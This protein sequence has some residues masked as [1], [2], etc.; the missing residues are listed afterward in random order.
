[1]MIHGSPLVSRPDTG[2]EENMMSLKV[3]AQ[4]GLFLDRNHMHRK[5]FRVANGRIVEAMGAVTTTCCFPNEPFRELTLRFYVL[6][7]LI[8]Q[9]VMG[10]PFLEETRVLVENRHRLQPRKRKS[11]HPQVSHVNNSKHRLRCAINEVSA[12]AVPDTGSDID[13]MSMEY[14]KRR[15]FV[16]EP[17]DRG[18]SHIQFIDGGTAVLAGKVT[19]YVIIDAEKEVMGMMTFHVLEEL[20][21]DILFGEHFLQSNE[22]FSKHSDHVIEDD[23]LSSSCDANGILWLSKT[24]ITLSRRVGKLFSG[25]MQSSGKFPQLK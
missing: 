8:A 19:V 9:L 3:V 5:S 21:C 7:T 25:T 14:V 13:L 12:L 23:V 10:L 6:P 15:S 1:M 2:C 24:E 18:V 4:L 17:V 22:I 11:K 20:T 16:M